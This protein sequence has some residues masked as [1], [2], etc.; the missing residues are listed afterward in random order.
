MGTSGMLVT[1]AAA[2]VADRGPWWFASAAGIAGILVGLL[3]KWGVDALQTHRRDAREDKLRFIQDK[4][5]AYSDLL[6]ACTEVADSEHDHRLLL[7]RS[8][9]LDD[10]DSWDNEEI[11][12]FNA[13]R[14][15]AMARREEAYR[16]VSR[17]VATV[18]LIAPPEV[19]SAA[20]LLAARCH[21]PHLHQPRVDAERSFVDAVRTEWS[22]PTTRDLAYVTYEPYIEY[23]SPDS[24][25]D[26]SEWQ[27]QSGG[28][29]VRCCVKPPLNPPRD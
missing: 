29:G 1:I 2:S 12:N 26:Q 25:I 14:D 24:G 19:V 10:A 13:D 16:A 27:P 9:R 4:R 21:H 22:Y 3:A 15:R 18:E 5:I 8:R 28:W 6:A 7:A 23:D 17:A 11:D 20:D